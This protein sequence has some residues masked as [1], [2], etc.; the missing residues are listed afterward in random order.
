MLFLCGLEVDHFVRPSLWKLSENTERIGQVGMNTNSEI[1]FI[2]L[3]WTV[4]VQHISVFSGSDAEM[5]HLSFCTAS[6]TSE[7]QC[8]S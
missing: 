6:A 2:V 8:P 1:H 3:L 5:L 7:T 4:I